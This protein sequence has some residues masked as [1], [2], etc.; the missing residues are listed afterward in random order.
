MKDFYFEKLHPIS[1][2]G[3]C[4][5]DN[6]EF[7]SDSHHL[8]EPNRGPTQFSVGQILI[9]LLVIGVSVGFFTN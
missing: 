8:Y 4:I 1:R 7:R 6:P 9:V 2:K 3:L 5:E